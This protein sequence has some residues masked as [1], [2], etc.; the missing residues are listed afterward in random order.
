MCWPTLPCQ[1]YALFHQQ[2]KDYGN[3]K[4]V[5]VS[6]S[7]R[8]SPCSGLRIAS[9]S[10]IS[11]VKA[12]PR[13]AIYIHSDLTLPNIHI[14]RNTLIRGHTLLIYIGNQ[15]QGHKITHANASVASPL[16]L[17]SKLRSLNTQTVTFRKRPFETALQ[18]AWCLVP[19]MLF[20]RAHPLLDRH[21]RVQR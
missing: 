9:K 8:L 1:S 14:C 7:P 21:L 11:N 18:T 19:S 12:C 15:T 5:G 4:D 10:R 13:R 2:P 16:C 17:D 3:K 6:F 20:I